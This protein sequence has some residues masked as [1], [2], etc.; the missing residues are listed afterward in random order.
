ML[1]EKF[2]FTYRRERG[3]PFAIF[4]ELLFVYF[5]A[6]E[7]CSYPRNAKGQFHIDYVVWWG[8][9]ECNSF[10]HAILKALVLWR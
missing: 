10:W 2:L 7:H 6:L 5:N 1:T 3:Q 8:Q 4:W 9:C